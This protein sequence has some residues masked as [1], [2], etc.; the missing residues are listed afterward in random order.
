MTDSPDASFIVKHPSWDDEGWTRVPN[1]IVRDRALSLDAK[2]LILFLAS[3]STSYRIDLNSLRIQVGVGR[4]KLRKLLREL[5][6]AGYLEREATFQLVDGLNRRGPN[7]YTLGR[8]RNQL[9]QPGFEA[10]GSEAPQNEAHGL[11]SS[12][13]ELPD[14]EAPGTEA[15]GNRADIKKT[16]DK[17]TTTVLAVADAPTPPKPKADPRGH[18]LPEDFVVT[19]E[20]VHWCRTEFPG[21]DGR[22]ETEKFRDFWHSKAGANARKVDWERTWKNWIRNAHDRQ[23]SR[24]GSRTRVY[25]GSNGAQIERY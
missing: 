11:T 1:E 10:S 21:V 23:R 24:P 2:G 16:N 9:Q 6:S 13:S 20:M 19:P 14:F 3:H 4:E 25:T 8:T 7:K 12:S 17:K 5:E 18:R 15:P 22:S